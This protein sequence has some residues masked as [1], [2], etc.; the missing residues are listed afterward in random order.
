MKKSI[1]IIALFIA[2]AS[3]VKSNAQT[4]TSFGVKLNGTLTN[5][6]LSDLQGSSTSFR[7]GVSTG[8]FAKIEFSEN[9]ALQPE[10][11]FS[12]TE[13]KVK[14]LGERNKFKYAA[15]EIPV[16]AVGQW[17][18][19]NGKMFLGAGPNIGY[20]FSIDSKTEKLPEGHPKENKIELDH[21]YMGGG[22]TAG[23]E[24]N[25][26]LMINA[27]YKMGWDLSS[28]NKSSDVKT[29]TISLGVGYKF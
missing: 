14:Y 6:K 18:V 26:G 4:T 10:L 15:V 3:M 24:F 20:G 8:G 23:Y 16:Y 12:Y 1:L 11:N 27:G 25:N 13:G 17:N 21:W 5:V 7:P 28:R 2:S 22:I 9:F 29:Q 19:G